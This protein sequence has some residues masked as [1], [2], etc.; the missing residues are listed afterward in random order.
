MRAARSCFVS[1]MNRQHL[2][3]A[4]THAEPEVQR[5]WR[6]DCNEHRM[7]YAL[8]RRSYR[9]FGQ[10]ADT[11]RDKMT[12]ARFESVARS[13]ELARGDYRSARSELTKGPSQAATADRIRMPA[14]SQ[15]VSLLHGRHA[16]GAWLPAAAR[17][18]HTMA[19]ATG[20]RARRR[21][22]RRGCKSS[23]AC[24]ATYPTTALALMRPLLAS[25]EH[26]WAYRG[27]LTRTSSSLSPLA[28]HA[29]YCAMVSGVC[30]AGVRK[31]TQKLGVEV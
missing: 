23:A 31:R 18:E 29:G 26:R 10:V 2:A 21:Q 12:R 16:A 9:I 14:I 17:R 25:S 30:R 13:C 7:R 20:N 22:P 24:R 5:D 15:I 4:A 1:A 3:G 27:A 11:R 6:R 28:D 8:A 19:N